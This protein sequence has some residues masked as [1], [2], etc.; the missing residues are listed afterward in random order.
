MRFIV[1]LFLPP[2]VSLCLAAGMPSSDDL[3]YTRPAD[4]RADALPWATGGESDTELPEPDREAWEN[5]ALPVGNGRIGA[6]VFGGA[7]LERLCLNEISLW[8]GG[9][10]HSPS[11]GNY[12]YGPT[13][14]S[15]QFGSYQPF[16]DLFI[17]FSSTGDNAYLSRSLNLAH[18]T[19]STHL[20][21]ARRS[22]F[23]SY[24]DDV[25]V[26]SAQDDS[27]AGM[28]AD[29]ALLPYH[30][31]TYEKVGENEWRMYGRLSNGE[32]FEARLLARVR[33]GSAELLGAS[34]NCRVL[35]EG[36]SVHMRP[37]RDVANIPY[38][39]IRGAHSFTLLVSLA[40]DYT[41]GY[42]SRYKGCSPQLRNERLLAAVREMDDSTLR[43][44]HIEAFGKLY[45]R[46]DL[47]LGLSSAEQSKLATDE[48][49]HLYGEKGDDPAL[50]ALL[51]RYG[52][53]LLIS[54]SRPGQL[55]M[56]LQGIWNNKVHAPWACD[57]H[58]NINLQMCYWGAEVANLS[59]CHEPL[60][61]FIRDM[62]SPLA[63]LVRRGDGEEAPW[64]TALRISQNPW[65]GTGWRR[66][67][68][69]A[70]AWYALHLWE[71]FLFSGNRDYLS[72]TA[73]PFL[74]NLSSSWLPRLKR[75]GPNGEGIHSDG[76]PLQTGDYPELR[77]LRQGTLVVPD[78]W[79]HEW[80]PIEDGCAHDQQL[81]RE[82]FEITAKAALVLHVDTDFAKELL[83]ASQWLAPDRVG[84]GG[85]LQEWIVDRPNMVKGHRHTSHLFA[86]YP[87]STISARRSPH[88][89]QA[90][91]VSLALRG[92]TEDNRRS[93]TWPWRAAL[94]ARLHDAEQAHA[95]VKNL[96]RYNTLDN[97]L[98]T[99][100]PMQIDGNM[101]ITAAICEMLLQSHD[102]TIELLPAIP[103]AWESGQVRGLRARG[104]ATVDMSWE[105]G[106]LRSWKIQSE[107][108]L[109]PITYRGKR[110]SVE[111]TLPQ[112]SSPDK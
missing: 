100:P 82:L 76:I 86:V 109:P 53:Y 89:M 79:S 90:A 47:Q 65:G 3:W 64:W 34:S 23:A 31:V 6:M 50:E 102:G 51:F 33:G 56:N 62:Q 42:A 13:S 2:A 46:A 17:R 105:N 104:G 39:S 22:C 95:M 27:A 83:A 55:P 96:L 58:N 44:R 35:Y 49:L 78:G 84:K 11:S 40:T 71:H 24:S 60:L 70:S 94:Y 66:R 108:P 59:E 106:Q 54:S 45:N 111:G 38:L 110:L 7:N 14:D 68:P 37:V 103:K 87:G 19:A 74:K 93:W 88:L 69:I 101:G 26:Y 29:V 4:V 25:I 52:R 81:M 43:K 48:R 73:Y 92:D 15:S 10:N 80:G 20:A 8:S 9:K 98:T 67:N 63:E 77:E 16:A 30:N 85:Y 112:P 12:E 18:A 107:R 32:L 36:E 61:H 5:A 21:H 99:H 1:S 97:L 57:Y 28:N 72:N 41:S 91:A 75:L